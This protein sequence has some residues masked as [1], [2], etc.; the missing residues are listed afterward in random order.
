MRSIEVSI[1]TF[2]LLW[3]VRL[4]SELSEEEIIRRLLRTT[5]DQSPSEGTAGGLPLSTTKPL[6][7]NTFM[8]R[9]KSKKWTDLLVWTLERLGGEAPLAEIYRV[10]REGRRAL[11]YM[12]TLHHDDSARECLESHCSNSK[13]WRGKADLFWMPHGKGAGIWALR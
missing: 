8:P 1:D 5:N 3:S 6:D 10:S 7:E 13:K 11:G 12:T 2:A 9:P 4:P